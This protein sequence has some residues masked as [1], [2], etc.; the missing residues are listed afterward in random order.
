[1]YAG[2]IACCSLVSHGQYADG[3]DR[4]ADRQ[5]DAGLPLDV[6]SVKKTKLKTPMTMKRYESP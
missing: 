6:A 5:T 1:M 2:R 4:L 3:T